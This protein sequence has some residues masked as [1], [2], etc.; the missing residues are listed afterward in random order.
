MFV[1]AIK[2]ENAPKAIGPYSPAVKLGDFVYLSGQIPVDPATNELVT[3][4]I[5]AQTHQVMQNILTIL[6]EMG[7]ETRHVVKTTVFL[8]DMND[9]AEFNKVYA[10]YFDEPYPARSCIQ[11]GALPKGANVE[12]E[13][14][15]ID[16]LQYEKPAEKSCCNGCSGCE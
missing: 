14:L 7:L 2:P 10:E 5:G 1:K 6:E 8:T 11:V 3:G 4:A 12:I 9:F 16:T 13:C 15:V